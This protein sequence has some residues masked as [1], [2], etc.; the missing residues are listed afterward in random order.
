MHAGADQLPG[1]TLLGRQLSLVS[2][3]VERSLNS[4]AHASRLHV[5]AA[6]LPCCAD[7]AWHASLV[8]P[9]ARSH[10]CVN[11]KRH[12]QLVPM[13]IRFLALTAAQS[14][15]LHI[16]RYLYSTVADVV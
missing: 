11:M 15:W 9:L 14:W 16:L 6:L 7:S 3:F 10:H 13:D 12:P 4:K 8:M 1:G 2:T 5:Q